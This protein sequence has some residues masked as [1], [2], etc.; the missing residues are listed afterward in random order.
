MSDPIR[1]FH[2]WATSVPWSPP[3]GW[4]GYI[5]WSPPPGWPG[6]IGWSPPPGWPPFGTWPVAAPT[7]IA[8]PPGVLPPRASSA[9]AI[10]RDVDSLLSSLS[11]EESVVRLLDQIDA[12]AVVDEYIQ[13]ACELVSAEVQPCLDD[14]DDGILIQL[15][16][17]KVRDLL[18]SPLIRTGVQALLRSGPKLVAATQSQLR[19]P[20]RAEVLRAASADLRQR[21]QSHP[22]TDERLKAAAQELANLLPEQIGPI[23]MGLLLAEALYV[24]YLIAGEVHAA[25]TG[26]PSPIFGP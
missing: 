1:E 21:R 22:S 23:L 17:A 7:G 11:P 3:P 25:V 2:H 19:G 13:T 12:L 20:I 9:N 15:L 26:Q 14:D 16:W 5:G 4:P 24:D 10:A 18:S 8:Q 6:Y